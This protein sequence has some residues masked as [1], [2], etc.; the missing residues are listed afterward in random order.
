[1]LLLFSAVFTILACTSGEGPLS[2]HLLSF[3]SRSESFQPL[4]IYCSM[5]TTGL[6]NTS[7]TAPVRQMGQMFF[8][9]FGWCWKRGQ[10]PGTFKPEGYITPVCAKAGRLQ[11]TAAAMSAFFIFFVLT[12]QYR[13][14]GNNSYNF[15][16]KGFAN[17]KFFKNILKGVPAG[18]P[19]C[20]CLHLSISTVNN[21][22]KGILVFPYSFTKLHRE[23]SSVAFCKKIQFQIFHFIPNFNSF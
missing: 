3:T 18:K 10:L 15:M 8:R 13:E 4:N 17:G 1:M 21:G 7:T 14:S 19:V 23:K 11:K 22:C 2:L 12:V 20:A 5:G 9:C 16:K 6:Q